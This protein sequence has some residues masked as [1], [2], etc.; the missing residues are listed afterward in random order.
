[1]KEYHIGFI[2]PSTDEEILE[3]DSLE[4]V[5][6]MSKS[7]LEIK[8]LM[9]DNKVHFTFYYNRENLEAFVRQIL[10][11][12]KAPYLENALTQIRRFFNVCSRDTSATTGLYQSD[13]TYVVWNINQSET[14]PATN[15]IKTLADNNRGNS[16]ACMISLKISDDYQR[17]IV[18]II[19][20]AIHLSEM[21]Q[22]SLVQYFHPIGS[23]TEEV[24]NDINQRNFTLRN[25]VKFDR[26]CY[27][28]KPSRQRIYQ[29]KETHDFWYYDFFH[30][31]KN[32][33]YEVFDS[34][35]YS[36]IG[37]ADMDGVVHP[38]KKDPKKSIKK[39]I[40]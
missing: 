4:V 39:Y 40:K 20:D 5:Q 13:C 30:H 7:L 10:E 2:F 38:E 18:P 12:D 22:L 35:S 23:F 33:H 9:K 27:T 11:L 31:T 16:C 24:N 17:D 14:E 26:T 1:M 3:I 19:V 6:E 29:S 25:V 21:P 36:H 37:E 28:Y 32:E 15:M 34:V 8:S